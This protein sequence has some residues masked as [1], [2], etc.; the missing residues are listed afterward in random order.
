MPRKSHN[1]S[2]HNR[3][4]TINPEK[5]LKTKLRARS[6]RKRTQA[7]YKFKKT[8]KQEKIQRLLREYFARKQDATNTVSIGK[9]QKLYRKSQSAFSQG[10]YG[11]GVYMLILASAIIATYVPHHMPD[12]TG[13]DGK[14]VDDIKG[15][16]EHNYEM[17]TN[18]NDYEWKNDREVQTAI[19]EIAEH[20]E[21]VAAHQDDKERLVS[22]K[23]LLL[24][25]LKESNK[26]E[27]GGMCD[28]FPCQ[29]QGGGANTPWGPSTFK[30]VRG[31]ND[32][33]IEHLLDEIAAGKPNPLSNFKVTNGGAKKKKKNKGTPEEQQP[34]LSDQEE[35]A[36]SAAVKSPFLTKKK[37][38]GDKFSKDPPMWAR[39]Y[40]YGR[41]FDGGENPGDKVWIVPSKF[42]DPTDPY[43]PINKLY[44]L[45]KKPGVMRGLFIKGHKG[46]WKLFDDKNKDMGFPF[47][48]DARDTI[49][50]LKIFDIKDKKCFTEKDLNQPDWIKCS[51][52]CFDVVNHLIKSE[53]HS[54]AFMLRLITN[55]LLTNNPKARIRF[56]FNGNIDTDLTGLWK[57]DK[58]KFELLPLEER[59]VTPRLIMCFGPSA[60]GKT[61]NA[62]KVLQ[63]IT[64]TDDTFPSALV[65]IDGG[66]AREMSAIYQMVV[67]KIHSVD[68]QMSGFSNLVS[69]GM[70]FS[71]SLFSS[72]PKKRLQE[73]LQQ[74]C[75]KNGYTSLYIPTTATGELTQAGSLKKAQKITNTP[76]VVIGGINFNNYKNLLLNKAN[77]LAISGYIWKNKKL[78]PKNAIKKLI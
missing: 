68:N 26:K 6:Q 16:L 3:R 34:L 15:Y 52:K 32:V 56:K 25:K 8:E 7:N 31:T 28:K 29:I 54:T 62:K 12:T 74:Q 63:L 24:E 5:S 23:N 27:D 78:K 36:I 22:T 58:D 77:F 45:L 48:D 76:I 72:E 37:A 10:N 11:R 14:T 50:K 51:D 59:K 39:N 19:K 73:F 57:A 41:Q 44:N 61:F 21:K 60:A 66:I 4:G 70:S 43:K 30:W 9:A 46:E 49:D 55:S 42:I 1:K 64:K 18:V 33:P 38:S 67:N 65:A 20:D 13:F 71:K 35:A 2:P 69:A 40:L 75:K 17:A 53:I 47:L